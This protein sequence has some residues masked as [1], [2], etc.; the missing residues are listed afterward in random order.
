MK[1][2]LLLNNIL[3]SSTNTFYELYS[4]QAMLS[5]P[6]VAEGTHKLLEPVSKMT[7]NFWAGVPISI[8]P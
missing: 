4:L 2:E 8:S 6:Q 7:V 3:S 1:K 5:H